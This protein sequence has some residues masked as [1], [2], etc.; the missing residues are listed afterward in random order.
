MLQDRRWGLY[1][2]LC[3]GR[4]SPFLWEVASVWFETRHETGFDRGPA[5]CGVRK[6]LPAVFIELAEGVL[7][8]HRADTFV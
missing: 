1:H 5:H 8:I 4:P 6:F 7:N 3:R 2:C